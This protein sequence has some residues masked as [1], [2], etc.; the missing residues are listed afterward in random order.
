MHQIVEPT[1]EEIDVRY[2]RSAPTFREVWSRMDEEF[3]AHLDRLMIRL[4]RGDIT[5]QD[6]Y[7]PS[8]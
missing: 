2:I 1:K 7:P 4:A 8:H 6:Q 5:S 3:T